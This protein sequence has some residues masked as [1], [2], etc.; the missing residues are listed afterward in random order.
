MILSLLD[1][2]ISL[3]VETYTARLICLLPDIPCGW[4]EK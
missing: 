2:H 1:E 4:I 3:V